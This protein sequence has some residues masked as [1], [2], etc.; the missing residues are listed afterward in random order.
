[1]PRQHDEWMAEM[2]EK[3][4]RLIETYKDKID[5]QAASDIARVDAWINDTYDEIVDVTTGCPFDH[6]E[7][8]LDVETAI[9]VDPSAIAL[10]K[11]VAGSSK[12]E[13]YAYG[14]GAA[15]VGFAAMGAYIYFSK[16]QQKVV[17]GEKKENLISADA[18]FQMV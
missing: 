16:K 9:D 4:P 2:S 17:E 7:E 11:R 1:M 5:A 15:S 14:F 18:E 12:Y 6:P 10:A 3:Y 13:R 8:E